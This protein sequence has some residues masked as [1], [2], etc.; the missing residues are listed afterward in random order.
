MI[1][2]NGFKVQEE[3]H[4]SNKSQIYRAINLESK[5]KV[6]LKILKENYPL[7]RDII[8]YRQEFEITNNNDYEGVIQ[9][10]D[11]FKAQEKNVIVFEDFGATSLN[12]LFYN[13]HLDL[14]T[15]LKIAINICEVLWKIHI[16]NIIHKDIN[17]SNIVFNTE[18]GQLKI[19][20]FGISTRL[21]H[22]KMTSENASILEGTLAYMSP[23]QTGRMNRAVDYRTDFYSLGLTFYEL[24]TG[25]KIFE[26][27]DAMEL[28]HFHIAREPVIPDEFKN[29]IPGILKKIILKLIAKNA[30]DRYQSAWG[31]RSD[32]EKCLEELVGIGEITDF[33]LGL[34]DIPHK[35][36][37]SQKLYGREG[38]ITFLSETFEKI[39]NGFTELV[40]VAGFSGIGKTSLVEEIFKMA[41]LNPGSEIGYPPF[42]C[43]GKFEQFQR[44]IP[45]SAI[46]QACSGIIRTILSE[47]QEVLN[48]WKEKLL[49]N[50]GVNAQLIVELLPEFETIIGKQPPIRELNSLEA[51][52]RL[53]ITF[54]RFI[55][56]FATKMRPVVFFLDDL[57]W[58][59]TASLNLLQNI[60]STENIEYFLCIG[61]FRDNEVDNGHSLTL[62]I[63]NIEKFKRVTTLHLQPLNESQVNRI[64]ADTLNTST[65]K[66]APLAKVVYGKTKGNPFFINELLKN[67]Y[68]KKVL[69]FNFSNYGWEWDQEILENLDISENVIHLVLQKL[70]KGSPESVELLRT[71]ACMGNYFSLKT[72]IDLLGNPVTVIAR[73]LREVIEIGAVIPLNNVY[74]ELRFIEE[75]NLNQSLLN[76]VYKFQHDKVQQASYLL[77]EKENLEMI[78]LS[79]GRLMQSKLSEKEKDGKIIEIVEQ[80]NKGSNLI[81]DFAERLELAELNLKAGNKAKLS[82][83]YRPALEF[84]AK[85]TGF[86]PENSWGDFYSLTFSLYKSF[87]EC[88][89][90]CG[91]FDLAESNAKLLINNSLTNI[92]KAEIYYLQAIQYTTMQ[93]LEIAIDIGRK[94]LS[95]LYV[96][97]FDDYSDELIMH[98][99][100]Q[101]GQ[102]LGQRKI[103]GLINENEISS[104][105]KKLVA[106]LLKGIMLPAYSLGKKNLIAFLIL[107]AVNLC[108][109]FGLVPESA[110]IFNVYAF[111]LGHIFGDLKTAFEFGKLSQSLVERFDDPRSKA[112]SI[113]TNVTFVQYWN[114]PPGIT[115]DSYKKVIETGLETGDLIYTSYACTNVLPWDN[116]L[117]LPTAIAEGE[118]Y[119]KIIRDI[120]FQDSLDAALVFQNLRLNLTGRI[121]EPYS[122]SNENFE[123]E[124]TLARLIQ[125][126]SYLILA[127]YNIYKIQ[128]CYHNENYE[129]ALYHVNEAEKL[130][131]SLAGQ[132]HMVDFTLFAFL[133]YSALYLVMKPEEQEITRLKLE[134]HLKQVTVWADNNPE[135]FQHLKY[136]F[137]AELARLDS[138]ILNADEKYKKAI[139]LA[140]K[141][142]FLH[143]EAIANEQAARL[144]EG[145][146]RED[147]SKIYLVK[148][149]YCY[150]L[151]G[152]TRKVELLD[153]K[154][155][156]LDLFKPEKNYNST[157]TRTGVE[158]LDIGTIIKSSQA[159]LSEKNLKVLLEKMIKLIIENGGAEKGILVLPKKDQWL[160]EA[161]YNVNTG[162]LKVL[163]SEPVC[164][165]SLAV[166]ILN[167][168]IRTGE[169]SVFNNILAEEK[170]T[171][172]PYIIKVKPL[173]V[174]CMP[175]K[176]QG[177]VQGVLYLENNLATDAFTEK[178]LEMLGL[179]SVQAAI[180]LENAIL[181]Q[182]LEQRV[183][184]RT[185]DLINANEN[186]KALNH[187]KNELLDIVTHNLKSP[188]GS[189]VGF[190]SSI[191]QIKDLTQ[192][193]IENYSFQ[194]LSGS[195]RMLGMIGDLLDINSI[196]EGNYKLKFENLDI[197]PFIEDLIL[198]YA[199]QL[200]VKQL[201]LNLSSD[202]ESIFLNI[203]E[204]WLA[205]IMDNLISNSI[206]FSNPGKN[207]SIQINFIGKTR[208]Q[209]I[210]QG[211]GFTDNDKQRLFQKF[212]RLSAIP[213]G[214]ETSSGLGLSIVKKMVEIMNGNVYCEST[215]GQGSVFTVEF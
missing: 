160:I 163:D 147:F 103:A 16:N 126:K 204:A 99:A 58:A 148:A 159:L 69:Y 161:E 189:V 128:P 17:P 120:R 5:Q 171:G 92:E 71:A 146:N 133:T 150:E 75:E 60:I 199:D 178:H 61:A 64:V 200:K 195:K 45:Y 143:H 165:Y 47:P 166:S 183:N 70:S 112:E 78:H 210:D 179:L 154:Y 203:D 85:G 185:I 155:S 145:I 192:E 37:I 82:A 9:S 142:S 81:K 170:F 62:A 151:W 149:R 23:E 15:F 214:G 68:E 10:F 11:F 101:V 36:C 100:L 205:Q 124:S 213:T 38:E 41:K 66:T 65:A 144:W 211:P 212:A 176:N 138:D 201:K 20:D 77:N 131:E 135:N 59:D 153:K 186:L 108:L 164:D 194:I 21:S 187:E 208:I 43:K 122:L 198:N 125:T 136:L 91:E 96:E 74:G 90:I 168:T 111:I 209:V 190:A 14:K 49:L 22:E 191:N 152:A 118:K 63:N 95:L 162:Y 24:L 116:S 102:N 76:S 3:L 7:P 86:L 121:K 28:I 57:Q 140:N 67:I 158:I 48:T 172:D 113:F 104:Y 130:I 46:S 202:A 8:R 181:Y 32:L 44:H 19:I 27:K 173:S 6:I 110:Y 129:L 18:T 72:L 215:P 206:K 89:Y 119:L 53:S 56:V 87:S 141:Y 93:K 2:I 207:I 35:F 80:L 157:S 182:E 73:A 97:I 1:S 193:E 196:E 188:L 84:F 106:K 30:E 169:S 50:L 34:Q 167:Y 52:N 33:E 55:R 31:I 177:N 156:Y 94:G 42:F 40:L 139:N 174:L 13:Q 127:L 83:A 79:I 137:E 105:E 88:A 107:N 26:T 114:Y 197:V 39:R 109:K 117:D 134:N 25:K 184:E 175:L 115:V 98:E 54:A 29:V 123:E 180:S 12:S 51:Q 4:N 132:A